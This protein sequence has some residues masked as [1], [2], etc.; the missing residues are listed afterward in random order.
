MHFFLSYFSKKY[1]NYLNEVFNV[2][3]ENNS[4]LTGCFEK[5]KCQ[6]RKTNTAQFTL[7]YIG[8]T[9]SNKTSNTFKSTKNLNTF[10]NNL[11]KHFLCELRNS[12]N[13]L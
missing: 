12:K 6:F 1:P 4:Q 10:K 11:K 9:C 8:P 13:S 7:S 3:I 2:A 5:L